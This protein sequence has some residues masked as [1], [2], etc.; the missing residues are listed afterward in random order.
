MTALLIE[1]VG[2]VGVFLGAQAYKAFFVNVD[3]E[4]VDARYEDED[5][6]VILVT[7]HEVWV[8]NVVAHDV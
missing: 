3:L 7:I 6:E 8:V 4:R 1:L 5:F 2:V